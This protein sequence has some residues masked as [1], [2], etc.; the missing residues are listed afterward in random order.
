MFKKNAAAR[1]INLLATMTVLGVQPEVNVSRNINLSALSATLTG[2]QF[3][4]SRPSRSRGVLRPQD[5]TRSNSATILLDLGR[6]L[7]RLGS[8]Y[9]FA[10]HRGTP[11]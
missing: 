6:R 3:C 9:I 5:V 1:K 7:N 2:G 8:D 10:L 11:R 4:A